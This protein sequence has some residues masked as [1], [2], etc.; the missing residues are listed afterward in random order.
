MR[1]EDESAV[2]QSSTQQLQEDDSLKL[3]VAEVDRL[4]NEFSLDE[5]LPREKVWCGVSRNDGRNGVCKYDK[6]LTKR[7]FNKHITQTETKR[8]HCA[9]VVNEKILAQGNRDGFIDTVRHELAHAICYGK[10][11]SSQDHNANWKEMASKLGADSSSYHNKRD[12]SNEY[13]YYITCP[14]CSMKAGRTK[15]SKVIKK[16]FNRKC[17]NCGHSPLSSYEKGQNKPKKG[18]VVEIKSIPWNNK[19]EWIAER[20]R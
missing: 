19:E 16:P 7:R 13:K 5:N 2:Q 17:N 15:R 8:G 18:G 12:R 1:K 6:K 14:N 11:G 10:Y 3:M 20:C 4:Y 9:I